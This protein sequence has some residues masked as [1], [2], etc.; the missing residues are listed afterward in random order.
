MGENSSHNPVST[1][2]D[3]HSQYGSVLGQDLKVIDLGQ[4]IFEGDA[5]KDHIDIILSDRLIQSHLIDLFD[6]ASWSGKLI[7]QLTIISEKKQTRGVPIQS[8]HREYSFFTCRI[9]QP[10]HRFSLQRI[11]SSRNKVF[12]LVQQDINRLFRA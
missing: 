7:C 9:N 3:L 12:G 6:L 1:D 11:I 5:I 10:H 2:V 4:S 8:S